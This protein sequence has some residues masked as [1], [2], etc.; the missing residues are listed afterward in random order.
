MV[1]GVRLGCIGLVGMEGKMARSVRLFPT[2]FPELE[3]LPELEVFPELDALPDPTSP[4]P[5]PSPQIVPIPSQRSPL[6]ISV[7]LL[8]TLPR[9]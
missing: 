2:V 1:F 5:L 6:W 4:T 7:V 8:V 9:S 3:V